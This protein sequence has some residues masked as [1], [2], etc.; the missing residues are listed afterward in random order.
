MQELTDLHAQPSPP[1]IGFTCT[2]SQKWEIGKDRAARL[3][4]HS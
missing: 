4:I 2:H 3:H 1:A